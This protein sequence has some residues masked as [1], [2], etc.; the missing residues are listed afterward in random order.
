[1]TLSTI[2][3]LGFKVRG[4]VKAYIKEFDVA[5]QL[6]IQAKLDKGSDLILLEDLY[7]VLGAE[8][9][10]EK[11]SVLWAIRRMKAKGSIKATE[12]RGCYQTV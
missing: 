7:S 5:A 8:E 4:E 6:I 11:V 9:R 10:S 1:M 12:I 3:D 2:S